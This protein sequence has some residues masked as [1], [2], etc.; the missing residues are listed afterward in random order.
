MKKRL[1]RL[2]VCA[3]ALAAGACQPR[4]R[5]KVVTVT[6]PAPPAANGAELVEFKKETFGTPLPLGLADP[7]CAMRSDS[8]ALQGLA[9]QS[10]WF[11]FQDTQEETISITTRILDARTFERELTNKTDMRY[12]VQG[13]RQELRLCD[14]PAPADSMEAIGLQLKKAVEDSFAFYQIVQN[15]APQLELPVMPAVGLGLFPQYKK[16]VKRVEQI[17]R[18]DGTK[19]QNATQ[20]VTIG[21]DNAFYS[22]FADDTL[23]PSIYNISVIPQ[24]VEAR[25]QGLY[26]GKGLWEFPVVI[27]H[28]YGHHVFQQLFGDSTVVSFQAYLDYWQS[29]RGL[30]SI[31]GSL[32]LQD[33][34]DN[35]ETRRERHAFL[36]SPGRIFGALNEGFSDLFAH[37]S[38][39]EA[40][41]LFDISCFQE[42]RDVLSPVMYGGL[43]KVW[44][45]DLWRETF[46]IT[47]RMGL[48]TV[49]KSEV[50]P[51][52]L[53]S[54]PSFDDIH[55][56]GAV[57]AHTVDSV[58]QTTV[59]ARREGLTPTL[60]KAGLLMQ[61]LQTLRATDEVL[62]LSSK[63][64]LSRIL[65]TALGTAL[66]AL[67][68]HDK[69]EY[70]SVVQQKFPVILARWKEKP[71][72]DA[73]DILEACPRVS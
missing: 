47:M 34:S 48:D 68:D 20:T 30:H 24:S 6:V 2:S 31:H 26:N 13:E 15:S 69:M 14:A 51:L 64:T 41:G 40:K 42:T 28:E 3:L 21:T 61:W 23:S 46:D 60:H 4:T 50:S 49:N 44:N 33:R 19:S 66:T 5:T 55:V 25:Q 57:L 62:E 67:G 70:C 7:S 53:C 39:N 9:V 65:N 10:A 32:G 12:T 72:E 45:E 37:Y 43:P 16:D 52:E 71:A 18:M 36:S 22:P 27:H 1:V 54:V 17:I 56:V 63:Q 38:L 58:F 11:G 73:A 35:P 59:V 8:Q 29:H